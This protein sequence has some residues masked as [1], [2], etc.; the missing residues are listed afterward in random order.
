MEVILALPTHQLGANTFAG[1][2]AAD[3]GGSGFKTN[4]TN[5]NM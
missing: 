2:Q 1:L 5:S 4:T 3:S